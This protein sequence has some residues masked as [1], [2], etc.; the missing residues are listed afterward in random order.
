MQKKITKISK[1]L[2]KHQER[3]NKKNPDRAL[4]VWETG[5]GKTVS[6]CI[7]IKRRLPTKFLVVCPKGIIEKWKRDLKEWGAKAD[8]V[9]RD[10][11]KKL[12]LNHYGGLVLD[13]AQ[14]FASPLFTKERSQRAEVIYKYI[15]THPNAY[16]LLLTATPVRSTAWNIHTLACYLG[17][18]W[19]VRKYRD[20]FFFM[21]DKYGCF[22]Y[23]KKDGWQK[24]IRSCVEK[25]SDIV[26]MSDCA[27]VPTQ[28][29]KIIQIPWTQKQENEVQ[30]Q[31]YAEPI[32]EWHTRHRLEQGEPK[33]EVLKN[34]I[35]G[36]RKVIIVAHYRSQID[37]YVAK[38]GDDRLVYVLNGSTKD[39]DK[40]IQDA[41]EADDCVF[42]IQASMGAGF[43]AGEFSVVIFASMSFRY[44]DHVQMKGRV[45]RINNLHEN[46]FIYLLAGKNDRAVYATIQE[47]K[48]FD[49]HDYLQSARP[50]THPQQE[51]SQDD[52]IGNGLVYEEPPF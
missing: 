18:Y 28:H 41:K 10:Q 23:E 5:T 25:I 20:M 24:M 51:G 46:T 37:D 35:D 27:D 36:Y 26:L 38:I 19:D 16:I 22:H 40:V 52:A 44:V 4:L 13:E 33:W 32:T 3:F 30:Q 34:L 9:S 43:D 48:N 7:W 21:T 47:N 15:K 8:V 11:I 45:K 6:A 39:Q 12:E 49:V 1:T 14:D 50:T 31:L 29:H 42:I 2:Y 17:Q